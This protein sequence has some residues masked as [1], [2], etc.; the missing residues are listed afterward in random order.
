[1]K[2]KW[3]AQKITCKW[4][5]ILSKA[6][7]CVVVARAQEEERHDLERSRS[8]RPTYRKNLEKAL[9]K[10]ILSNNYQLS[11]LFLIF[12]TLWMQKKKNWIV[13]CFCITIDKCKNEVSDL[14]KKL[15]NQTRTQE[16]NVKQ[17]ASILAALNEISAALT[18]FPHVYL[19]MYF[20]YI[21]LSWNWRTFVL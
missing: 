3:E 7:N 16:K 2:K 6:G 1:M 18:C 13:L 20:F 17:V 14:Q 5:R 21:L 15:E 4:F 19:T 10:K 12:R 8:I 11:L 9:K